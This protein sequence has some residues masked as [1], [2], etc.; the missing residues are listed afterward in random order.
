MTPRETFDVDNRDKASF[1]LRSNYQRVR[2][3]KTEC[4]TRTWKIRPNEVPITLGQSLFVNEPSKG[5]NT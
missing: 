4:G 5:R 1:I 3:A 2:I